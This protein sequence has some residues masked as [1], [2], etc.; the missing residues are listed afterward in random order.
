VVGDDGDRLC[1]AEAA[2]GTVNVGEFCGRSVKLT[3]ELGGGMIWNGSESLAMSSAG[4]RLRDLLFRVG[5]PAGGDD[6]QGS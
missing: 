5:C 4:L 1:G 3:G 6:N 2:V